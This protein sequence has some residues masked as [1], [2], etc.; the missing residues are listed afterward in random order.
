MWIVF[1]LSSFLDILLTCNKLHILKVYNLISVDTCT[2]LCN[3]LQDQD[4]QHACH[5]QMSPCVPGQ[6]LPLAP[7]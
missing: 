7:P 2:H 5:S 1:S 6:T 4:N 3:H